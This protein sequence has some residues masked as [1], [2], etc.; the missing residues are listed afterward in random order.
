MQRRFRQRGPLPGYAHDPPRGVYIFKQHVVG[1]GNGDQE[2]L[3][4]HAELQLR[5]LGVR[6][7]GHAAIEA[8]RAALF[9]RKAHTVQNPPHFA[10]TRHDAV[11]ALQRLRTAFPHQSGKPIPVFRVHDPKK[12]VLEPV[13]QLFT[14][15]ARKL[16]ASLVDIEHP[17]IIARTLYDAAR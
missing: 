8:R 12:H 1:M 2:T 5:F 9:H 3:V 13:F 10:G 16:Q 6:D 15:I 14:R 11:F 4:A 17:E 7:V